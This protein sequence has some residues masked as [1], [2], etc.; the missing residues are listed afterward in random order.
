MLGGAVVCRGVAV[1]R[2]W[3]HGGDRRLA[4]S[5]LALDELA[6][7]CRRR[8]VPLHYA[9]LRRDHVTC[10]G[11]CDGRSTGDL[12]DRARFADLHARLE[13]LGEHERNVV[14]TDGT[15]DEVAATVPDRV[16]VGKARR[17]REPAGRVPEGSCESDPIGSGTAVLEDA[18]GAASQC[19][20]RSTRL[21]TLPFGWRGSSSTSS[22]IAGT[23]KSARC[24]RQCS[25]QLVG[26]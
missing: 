26:A 12:G 2:R 7:A 5:H 24:A 15:P 6:P 21:R 23:L 18:G 4:A 16:P 20:S 11:A 9:V 19:C 10:S 1:R 3:L 22:I 17:D 25:R 14:E 8:S 13:D